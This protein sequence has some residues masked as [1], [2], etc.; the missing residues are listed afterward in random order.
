MAAL[1]GLL[2]LGLPIRCVA[3]NAIGNYDTHGNQPQALTDML[4]V[5]AETLLAFQ[6]DLEARGL[7]DRVVV[8]VWSE[9]GRRVAENGSLGTDHG[10]AGLGLVIGSRVQG[11]LVGEF[12]GLQQLDEHGN[13]RTTI[14]FRAVYAALLEQW[15][16][17]DPAAVLPEAARFARPRLIR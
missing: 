16:G 14:D 6:R 1:A 11:G 15:L 10:A 5:T 3:V 13:L 9:F 7:A 12:P 2:G 8:H 4:K 17:A